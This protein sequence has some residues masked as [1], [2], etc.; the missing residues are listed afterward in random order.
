MT[1]MTLYL[2]WISRVNTQGVLLANIG[3]PQKLFGVPN[4]ALPNRNDR[5]L[6]NRHRQHRVTFIV[7]VFPNQIH[8]P[9]ITSTK[10][11]L[12]I[13]IMTLVKK[14]RTYNYTDLRFE[15]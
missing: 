14:K 4:I 3:Y 6:P 11:Q 7:N 13:L 5:V 1:N 10:S 9:C 2:V 12:N 8:S 15:V